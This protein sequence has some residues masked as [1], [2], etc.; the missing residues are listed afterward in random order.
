MIDEAIGRSEPPA[1][2]AVGIVED[3]AL[4]RQ[5]LIDT[6]NQVPGLRVAGEAA[7]LAE[8]FALA[9]S[10]P[11]V[12]LIDLLLPDGN[13]T[14]LIQYVRQRYSSCRVLVL[15]VFGDGDKVLSA[16][17]AGADGYLLKGAPTSEVASCIKT[18]L[19][20]GAPI[21]P[22]V[23]IHILGRLR[24][25]ASAASRR[26]VQSRD[27]VQLTATEVKVLESLAKGLSFKEA[28]AVHGV[29]R[30]TIT[31]HVKAIYRKLNVNS[32]GEAVFEGCQAGLIQ[33]RE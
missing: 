27:R 2:A 19:E 14:Q 18:V 31:D 8:G 25:P 5:V 3:D 17:D 11:D 26:D 24:R 33:L 32:R 22:A 29:S 6:V 9:Q 23:A 28:A 12:L 13:G 1:T 30:H 16:I 7:T 4:L 10:A 20:G 15:S 21:S